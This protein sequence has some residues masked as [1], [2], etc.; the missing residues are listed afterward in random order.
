LNDVIK[1]ENTAELVARVMKVRNS[2][3]FFVE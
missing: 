3:E 2:P 1:A